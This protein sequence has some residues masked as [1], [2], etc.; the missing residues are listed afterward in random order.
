MAALAPL[1]A[2]GPVSGVGSPASTDNSMV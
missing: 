2:A 1:P